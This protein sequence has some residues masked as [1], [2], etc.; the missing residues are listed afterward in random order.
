MIKLVE[1]KHFDNFILVCIF[2][3]L[4]AM[5]T[6]DY[7]A[8]NERLYMLK[9]CKEEHDCSCLPKSEWNEILNTIGMVFGCIFSLEA[10]MKIF[11]QGMLCGTKT[12]FKDGWNVIDFVIVGGFIVEI[13]LMYANLNI[14]SLRPLRTLRI[15]RPLKGLKTIPSLRK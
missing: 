14:L 9:K 7:S 6:F 2:L 10:F 15:L 1:H 12:Y 8:D 11:A 3:N 5:T 13:V 4:I